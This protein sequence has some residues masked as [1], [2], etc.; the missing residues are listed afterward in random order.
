MSKYKFDCLK[1]KGYKPCAARKTCVSCDEYEPWDRKIV[2][3]KLGALG[4]VMRTTPVL[5][6]LRRRFPRAHIT[7]VTKKNAKEML[8]TTPRINRL[9]Y[10]DDND[11]GGTLRLMAEEF[12][13]LHCYDK[14]DA[15]IGLATLIKAKKKYGFHLNSFGQMA[16]INAKSEYCFDLGLSDDLKFNKNTKSYQEVTYECSELEIPEPMDPYDFSLRDSD[17]EA[18]KFLMKRLRW[19]TKRG[20]S[21]PPIIG[22][23]TGSGRVFR[24]KQWLEEYFIE[25]AKHLKKK[26][27][28]R[29]L[30][31]GGEDEDA[32]N[33]R[34]ATKL[35]GIAHYPG[36]GFSIRQFAGVIE[37]CDLL[38]TGDTL[39]M[40]LALALG[41]RTVTLFGS[42]CEQEV[43]M[44]GLGKKLVGKPAC[45]PC[46]KNECDKPEWMKC[47]KDIE[48]IMVLR[49]IGE[50]LGASRPPHR[51]A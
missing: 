1:F 17:R 7:W 19:D 15:A 21:R 28:A 43:D 39:A 35:K 50:V 51:P 47:M 16:P 36:C 34:L 3:V 24:T 44:Y 48:P 31:L 25:L 11:N 32:R 2:I 30:L 41:T 27:K 26:M 40:H 14:E 42:T 49:A 6:A 10:V 12:D 18:A 9:V 8:E 23:N 33:Q 20:V 38:V 22:L 46:Y 13:E 4:D 5:F 45:A 29:V 37:Q